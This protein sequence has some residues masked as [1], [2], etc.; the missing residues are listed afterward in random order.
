MYYALLYETVSDHAERRKPFRGEHLALAEAFHRE[1]KLVMAGAFNPIEGA[2]LVFRA[3]SPAEV[4]EFVK[5]DPYVRNGLVTSWR[6][7][8]WTVVVG[9]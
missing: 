8:E 7:R 2:L 5:R 6:I 4:E 3:G 1:G 9:G